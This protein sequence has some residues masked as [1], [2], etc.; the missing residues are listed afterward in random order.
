MES[1]S[2]R[3]WIPQFKWQYVEWMN[4]N[5][6]NNQAGEKISWNKYSLKQLRSIYIRHRLKHG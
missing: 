5:V 3:F 4:T 6:P 1:L 2:Y